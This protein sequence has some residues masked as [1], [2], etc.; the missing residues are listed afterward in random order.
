[1]KR[2]TPTAILAAALLVK[3]GAAFGQENLMVRPVEDSAI[4]VDGQLTETVWT[5]EPPLGGF[6]YL[7][8]FNPTG[9][10]RAQTRLRILAGQNAVYLAVVCDEP[11]MAKLAD[12]PCLRD[13]MKVFVRDCIEIFVDPTGRGTEYYQFA[14]SAG[15]DLFDAY[16]IESGNT[17]GGHYSSVIES[18][19]GKSADGW[20]LEVRIPLGAFYFTEAEAFSDTWLLN[21]ARERQPVVELSTWSPLVRGFH[22]PQHFNRLSGMPRKDPRFDLWTSRMTAL[23]F[24][25]VAEGFT[26]ILEIE[27]EAGALAA[28]EYQVEA[29]AGKKRVAA[30]TVAIAVGKGTVR[31]PGAAFPVEGRHDVQVVFRDSQ[32]T[33]AHAM[34][35]PLVVQYEPIQVLITEPFYARCIFPDETVSRIAGSVRINLPADDLVGAELEVALDQASALR[36]PI[37]DHV[38]AFAVPAADLPVGDHALRCRVLV[39]DAER[40]RTTVNVRR[41]APP[42]TGRSVR[43]D[44]GLNMVVDGQPRFVRGWYGN[45]VYGI[46]AVLREKHGDRP[47]SP[48]VNEWES[49]MGMEAERMDATERERISTDV[50]PSDK[51]FEE[52]RKRIDQVRSDPKFTCYY[53]ADE[54]SYRSLSPVYLKHQYDFIKELDPYHPVMIIDPAAHLYK[55]CADII[56][57]HPYLNPTLD[58]GKRGMKPPTRIV[59]TVQAVLEAGEGRV[60]PWCT[61]QAFSYAGVRDV[62]AQYPTF[63]EFRCMVYTAVAAGAKGLTPFMYCAHFGTPDLRIGC[64]FIYETLARLE[65]F[66]VSLEP[67]LSLRVQA[68]EDGVIAWAKTVDG[69]TLLIAVN[70]LDCP[71]EAVVAGLPGSSPLFG[72]RQADGAA[73]EEGRATLRFA[74]YQVHLLTSKKMGEELKTVAECQAE[75][76][77]ANAALRKPGNLLFD[78]GLALE[79][80]PAQSPGGW[81]SIHQ[82]CDGVTDVLAFNAAANGPCEVAFGTPGVSTMATRIVVYGSNGGA[83]QVLAWRDAAWVEVG[84]TP[85]EPETGRAE[86]VLPEAVSAVKFKLSFPDIRK[87]AKLEL[88]EIELYAD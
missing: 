14:I 64:D 46:S 21:V 1:M 62:F 45:H 39:G 83:M 47:N 9:E 73:V 78:R 34:F 49:S 33:T 35:Y 41:L 19:V 17:T 84:R 66:L 30:G 53:L 65:P 2:T 54:P 42:K 22:E 68:P 52:M 69:V 61:P 24:A 56:N 71:V 48:H 51:V 50:R 28:G 88:Y 5:E 75:I 15:N 12:A 44:R 86:L 23:P 72:F 81:G 29:M 31:I 37:R 38:A 43:I 16:F 76:A 36:F 57:P 32:G 67:V 8:A 79:W 63:G 59:R 3:G 6:A 40:A 10:P 27:T 74:P 7:P 11:D 18:A 87:D 25:R 55:D 20:T 26:G 58:D 70:L 13:S 80:S 85:W 60:A 77:F 4:T 82:L